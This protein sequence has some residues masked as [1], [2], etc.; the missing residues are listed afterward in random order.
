M[1]QCQNLIDTTE[2]KL[3]LEPEVVL[4]QMCDAKVRSYGGQT[5]LTQRP[6]KTD[7]NITAKRVKIQD[8]DDRPRDARRRH[9]L[10]M[11]L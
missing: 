6:P 9:L 3:G 7:E 8:L 10:V 11:Y 5:A 1:L 2:G 4:L